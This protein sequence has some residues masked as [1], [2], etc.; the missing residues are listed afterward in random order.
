LLV[1]SIAIAYMYIKYADSPL[2][3]S[4]EMRVKGEN[5]YNS[6]GGVGSGRLKYWAQA[7]ENWQSEGLP[8]IVIGLGMELTKDKM[9]EGTGRRLFAH[10]GFLQQL[11]AE[12]LIGFILLLLFLYFLYRFIRKYKISPYYT[13]LLAIYSEFI[14]YM[15]FQGGNYFLYY[16]IFA[17]YI[18]ILPKTTMQGIN[19]NLKEDTYG[20]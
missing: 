18:A 3:T 10:N 8:S 7:I 14:V 5:K 4:F 12:G 6:T 13:L 1:F 9:E 17:T 15:F 20:K 19:D 2:V 16:V 11:Q